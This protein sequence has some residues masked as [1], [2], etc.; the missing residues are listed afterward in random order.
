MRYIKVLMLFTKYPEVQ[1]K[2]AISSRN[3]I[4]VRTK[5][6][7]RENPNVYK[8]KTSVVFCSFVR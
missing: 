5:R 8:G 3:W 2:A 6:I 4:I 1:V 7:C